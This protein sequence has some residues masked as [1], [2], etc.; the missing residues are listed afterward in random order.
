MPRRVLRIE[1][2]GEGLNKSLYDESKSTYHA[3]LAIDPMAQSAGTIRTSGVIRPVGYTKFSGT[4]FTGAPMWIT[5]QPKT[6]NSYVYSSDGKLH[7]FDNTITMRATDE[8]GTSFPITIT[9]GAGNGMVYYDNF[10]YLA[11]ATD[12]SQ[13]GGMDQGASIAKTENVWT[14]AKFSKTALTNTTYPQLRGIT[15]PNHPMHLHSAMNAVI[16]GDVYPTT[17]AADLVNHGTI[18]ILATKRTTIQGDT[19]D[20]SVY[21]ALTLPA[22]YYPT[23][24]ESYGTDI[25]I[26]CIQTSGATNPKIAQGKSALFFWDPSQQTTTGA[27]SF[28]RMIELRDPLVTALLNQNG[29]IF[30]FSGDAQS[31]ARV[32]VYSGGDGVRELFYEEEGVS[33]FAGAVDAYA[34]RTVFGGYVSY[35]Q[36]AACVFAWGAYDSRFNESLHNIVRATAA[37][38]TPVVTSL[39]YVEQHVSVNTPRLIVGWANQ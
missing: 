5:T 39:K 20:A 23:D 6:E 14:G 29:R 26:A 30:V 15:I 8:A 3:G 28:Y 1:S 35:P 21:G 32:S 4:E 31:G 22:G 37:S 19:D 24:I 7:S 25:V 13:Y 2:I 33:P 16:I 17:A 36:D 12:I 34:T 11:E 9:G 27:T 10:I 18:H 38:S